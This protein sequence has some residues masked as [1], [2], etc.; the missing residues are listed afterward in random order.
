MWTR[1][2]LSITATLDL[3]LPPVCLLCANQLT[4]RTSTALCPD[5]LAKVAPVGPGHCT[6]CA[7]PFQSPASN[8]LCGNCLQR[9]PAFSVVHA[10]GVFQGSI[11]DA[12]HRLK[13]RN[14]LALAK[15]LGDLISGSLPAKDD[16]FKPDR[17]IPVPLHIK[18][19][20]RRGYNQALE[21]SRPVARSLQVPLDTVMLQRTRYNPPQQGLPA[22]DRRKNLRNVFTLT[23]QPT[24]ERVLLI[25][26]VMT[27]GETLREC[28]R[29]LLEG[30][31]LEVR[32]AVAGR[33]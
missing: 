14:Q 6:C 27:T 18:R 22:R 1:C 11:Q 2:R 16:S 25:D 30:G 13:Y 3:L 24:A 20:R 21:I 15:P 33:A 26:D 31:A 5:C 29:I 4:S 32:A 10:A 17:I 7:Q 28:S 23:T 19:L 8:H 9:P 12:V